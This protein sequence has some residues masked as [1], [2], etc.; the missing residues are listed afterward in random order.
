VARL[1]KRRRPGFGEKMG[2][3][4]RFVWLVLYY[5]FSAVFKLRYKHMDRLPLDGPMIIVVNHVSHVDPFLVAKFVLDA[6]RTPRFLAKESI[7]EVPAVGPAMRA[8]GHIPVKRGTTDARQSLAAAVACLDAGGVIVLHPEGT[9]TRDPHWWPMAGKT[10]AARLA[11]LVP[12]VPVIPIVQWGVQ[13]QVNLYQK[14]LKLFPRPR[15]VMSVGEPIELS[16]FRDREPAPRMLRE[17]TDVIMR[18]LR[19]DLAE[20]RG[21]P[22]PQG[23]LFVWRRGSAGQDDAA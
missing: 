5:P 21:E 19:H 17:M 10:G 18:R 14:R 9:V 23:D 1:H 6:A 13:E 16:A 15:H 3:G 2:A 20:L 7:F 12:D 4:W 11:S 8:M 22:A